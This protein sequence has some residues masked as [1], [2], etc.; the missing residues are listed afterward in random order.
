MS[1]LN[2]LA[3]ALIVTVVSSS[4]LAENWPQWR[5]PLGTGVAPDADPPTTWSESQ[6]IK[7]KVRIPGGG[8]ATPIVWGNQVFIQTAIPQA[9]QAAEAT[10]A[11]GADVIGF[12]AEPPR[13]GGR[14]G[15]GG[16]FGRGGAPTQPYQFALLCIDRATG[17]TVWEKVAKQEIPHEGTHGT[18]TFASH[19]PVTDGQVVIAFFGSRGVHC[20]D[21]QGNLKWSEDLG[22][23]R[24]KNGFGEGAS[25]ALAGD[26]LIVQWD[27]EGED[28]IAAFNKNTGD[29]IWRTPRD[30]DTTWSTPL[31]VQHEGKFQIITAATGKVVS[32][33]LETGKEIWSHAGLTANTIPTPVYAD[34]V[35]YVTAGFR[36]SALYAIRLGKTGNLT[37]TDAVVWSHKKSTPYVPS[38]L[39]YGNRLYFY[40]SNNAILSIFDARTGKAL[41]DSQR[42]DAPRSVYASPVGAAG[43]VYLTGREGTVAVIK[44]ADQ[45]EVLAT[46]RLDE[47]IDA[48]PAIAGKEIFLRGK[49]HLYCIAEK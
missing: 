21:M 28:F 39:L 20:F 46:N 18:N 34:G 47:G 27:H 14:G 38:P 40:A 33:D 6:N 41:V 9:G 49:E 26:K 7:W 19:S 12:Q 10:P 16:G 43:K 2:L 25:P 4:A 45:I 42:L 24:A 30:E 8:S 31:V 11:E 22:R 15:R 44:D 1:R 32:Y 17:K 35:V 5:G 23:M 37:G 3:C 36:G 13:R 29:E 48:S